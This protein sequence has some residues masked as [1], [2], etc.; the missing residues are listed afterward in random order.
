M[1]LYVKD[2]WKYLC[3]KK[4]GRYSS[5]LRFVNSCLIVLYFMTIRFKTRVLFTG[6][7]FFLRLNVQSFS[8]RLR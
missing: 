6:A 5:D 1:F 4:N 7:K 3:L 2:T 8:D